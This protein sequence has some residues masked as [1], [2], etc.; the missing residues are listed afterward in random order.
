MQMR[1]PGDELF[2]VLR[3]LEM[4]TRI[5]QNYVSELDYR[6]KWNC[7]NSPA[8]D[9]RNVSNAKLRRRIETLE[10]TMAMRL[11]YI[12]EQRDLLF[13]QLERKYSE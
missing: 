5:Y 6:V 7:E 3:G 11:N 8:G 10:E 4:D 1:T 2:S 12:K 9:Y 13:Q